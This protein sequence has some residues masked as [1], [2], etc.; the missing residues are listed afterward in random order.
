MGRYTKRYT[1]FGIGFGFAFPIMSLG[2]DMGVFH[3]S[4]FSLPNLWEIHLQNPLHF[5]IDSAPIFLGLAFGIAGRYLDKASRAKDRLQA[6]NEELMGKNEEILSQTEEMM[7][8]KE[9]LQ[10]QAQQLSKTNERMKSSLTYARR[11]QR[12]TLTAEGQEGQ[13]DPNSLLIYLRPKDVVCGDFY[14]MHESEDY[15]FLAAIDCT[16]HG[17]PSAFMTIIGNNL[18]NNIVVNKQ[19][20]EPAKILEQLD[21]QLLNTLRTEDAE[22]IQMINDGMDVAICRISKKDHTVTFS[23]AKR[24]AVIVNPKE[25]SMVKGGKFPIGSFQFTNKEFFQETIRYQSG[26]MLYLFTD[27]MTDQ[28]GGPNNRKFLNQNFRKLLQKYCTH[29]LQEQRVNIDQEM[30]E[31]QGY[32]QQTDDMLLL[33]VRL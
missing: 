9:L 4:P 25:I 16:G 19:E 10:A 15:K 1:L 32:H 2:L 8:Q 18:L 13:V 3:P 31:W 21:Q 20:I 33:G 23:G 26:D 11:I 5:I 27:G 12:A 28:F 30:R 17:V 7:A 14:W 29:S 22:G 24:P 6:S